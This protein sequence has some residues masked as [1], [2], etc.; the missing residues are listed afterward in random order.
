MIDM[1]KRRKIQ[2]LRRANHSLDKVVDLARVSRRSVVRVEVEPAVR[3]RGG[4]EPH[5]RSPSRGDAVL[6]R[7][8]GRL[9]LP[10]AKQRS[11]ATGSA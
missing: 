10:V 1:L 3:V 9:N 5:D 7:E 6:W 11:V 4:A 8:S 2:V